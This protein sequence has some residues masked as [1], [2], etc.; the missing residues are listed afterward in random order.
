MVAWKPEVHFRKSVKSCTPDSKSP[1][2]KQQTFSMITFMFS[3]APD[4]SMLLAWFLDVTF[5]QKCNMADE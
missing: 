2:Y 1:D 4:L 3:W 5:H